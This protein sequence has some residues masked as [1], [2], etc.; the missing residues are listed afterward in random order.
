MHVVAH[1][2]VVAGDGVGADFLEC[3]TLVRVSGGV[4]DCAGEEVLG[5]LCSSRR[6]VVATAAST[7]TPPTT[8][9]FCRALALA[10]VAIPIGLVFQDDVGAGRWHLV[11]RGVHQLGRYLLGMNSLRRRLFV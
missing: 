3:V 11:L 4:V 8:T 6:S 2:A 5:Q 7:A 9:A 1:E 10:G